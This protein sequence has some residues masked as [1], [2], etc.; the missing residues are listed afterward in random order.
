MDSYAF[1]KFMGINFLEDDVL[2]ATTL[3]DSHHLLEGNGLNKLFFKAIN[4]V[5]VATGH[6]VKGGTIVDT[7]IIDA[8][9][10]T[11]GIGEE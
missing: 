5:M 9:N 7:T 2:D 11:S 6:M 1:Q 8:P 4:R 3:L 10:S